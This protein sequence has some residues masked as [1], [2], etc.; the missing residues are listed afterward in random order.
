ME[1]FFARNLEK[2]NLEKSVQQVVKKYSEQKIHLKAFVIGQCK[3][4]SVCT[5]VYIVYT[6]VIPVELVTKKR[7]EIN[8]NLIFQ[9]RNIASQSLF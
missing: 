1:L 5:C 9:K 2:Q 6:K 4:V 3:F 8:K 7:K